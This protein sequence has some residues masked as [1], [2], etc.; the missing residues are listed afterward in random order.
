LIKFEHINAVSTDDA[1]SALRRYGEGARLI[2]GGQDLLFRIKKYLVQP[3]CIINLKTIPHLNYIRPSAQSNLRIGALT[4]LSEIARSAE[5]QRGYAALAQAAGVVASPQIR[6]MGTLAGNICQD[7]WCWYL[8]DGFS[9]WKSGGKFCDLAGGDSRYYGSIMGGHLCLSNHPSDTAVALAALD[10]K[11]HVASA[12]GVRVASMSE[13]LCG[14]N[15]IGPR[16]QS[17]TLAL[18]ELVTEIEIPFRPTR[19]AYVKFALRKSW[20]FA[21]AS[22][23][24]SAV[25]QD[26]VWKD[27]RIVLGGVATSPHRCAEAEALVVNRTM[28]AELA[29]AAAQAALKA[30]KPLRMNGY[31]VDL[32]KTLIRRALV[33]LE[34]QDSKPTE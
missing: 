12:R 16:L 17:H 13:F 8:Q 30:A 6:N 20:D 21:I 18:D 23:A 32:S 31:K 15:W 25:M 24:V 7:V 4:T 34:E 3:E 11:I 22:V 28:S 26:R 14:H 19:S 5:L 2:A 1:L 29:D 10:A 33:S 27:V 9:C